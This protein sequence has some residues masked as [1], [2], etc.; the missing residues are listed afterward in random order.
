MTCNK[1]YSFKSKV[2]TLTRKFIFCEKAK[3]PENHQI[4]WNSLYLHS[5]SNFVM[6]GNLDAQ[7]SGFVL[8]D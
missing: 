3:T 2:N 6:K 8:V 5:F 7:L 1:Y 4:G